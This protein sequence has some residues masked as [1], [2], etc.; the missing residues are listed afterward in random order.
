M[1]ATA[2]SFARRNSPRALAF[3]HYEPLGLIGCTHCGF[4][5]REVLE[6][7]HLDYDHSNNDMANL[8]I[9]CPNCHKMHQLD[10][11]ST[12][13][14]VLMRDNPK[15]IAQPRSAEKRMLK[16]TISSGRRAMARA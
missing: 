10:M 13:T 15:S 8:A 1:T 6:V 3:A 5:V 9:L 11:I 14:I 2:T 12:D 4:D 7:A 16:R